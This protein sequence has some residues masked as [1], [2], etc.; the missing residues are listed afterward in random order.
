MTMIVCRT[1]RITARLRTVTTTVKSRHSSGASQSFSLVREAA[2]PR[3]SFLCCAAP[4][5]CRC[6]WLSHRPGHSAADHVGGL[7]TVYLGVL[8][9]D[10]SGASLLGTGHAVQSCATCA[11]QDICISVFALSQSHRVE[12]TWPCCV[13]AQAVRALHPHP[14][15][16]PPRRQQQSGGADAAGRPAKSGGGGGEGKHSKGK[17]GGGKGGGGKGSRKDR[18]GR[19]EQPAPSSRRVIP[20]YGA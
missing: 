19:Q 7:L 8:S 10:C 4:L 2:A 1:L 18:H 20:I 16:P 11:G 13:Q 9:R 15:Q 17:H 5:S 3:Y 12:V 6:F 14:Q